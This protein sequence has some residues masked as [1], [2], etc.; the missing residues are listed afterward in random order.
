MSNFDIELVVDGQSMETI[1]ISQTIE[2]FSEADFQFSV[3]QDFSIIG[4]YNVT[5]NLSH[6]ND[7]YENNDALSV[8]LSNINELDGAIS[9]GEV[10]VVCDN[11]VEATAII[12]N[13]GETTITEVTIEVVVNGQIVDTISTSVDI[14]S[15]DQGTV[16]FTISDNLQLNNTIVLNLLNVN[17]QVDNNLVNNSVSTTTTLDSDYDYITLIINADDYAQ[18]TSWKLLNEAN[19]IVS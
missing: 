7:Q 2:P 13:Q 15:Q 3:P 5:V 8:T 18:E 14:L 9:V 1:T 16:S 4:D 12:S 17:D 6:A 11:E 10:S 19:E